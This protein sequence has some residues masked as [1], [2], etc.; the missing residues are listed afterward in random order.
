MKEKHEKISVIEWMMKIN[1]ISP[2]IKKSMKEKSSVEAFA[3]TIKDNPQ[4]IIEWAESE[5]RE[6]KKLIAI[7][8]NRQSINQKKV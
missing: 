3:D 1:P 7:L 5:I 6:Y 4:A 2:L 8:K